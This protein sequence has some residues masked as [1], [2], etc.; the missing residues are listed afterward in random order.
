MTDEDPPSLE[1]SNVQGNVNDLADLFA[2]TSISETRPAPLKP[3]VPVPNKPV[4]LVS[5]EGSGLR[6]V[7]HGELVPQSSLVELATLASKYE[8]AWSDVYS[9]LFLSQTPILK[10]AKH[11]DGAVNTIQTY[12]KGSE[13]LRKAHSDLSQDLRGLVTLLVEMRAVVL[14][15]KNLNKP[16]S[17]YWSGTGDLKVRTVERRGNL[18]SAGELAMF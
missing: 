17:F 9:Q 12:T 6:H 4:Q 3:V 11:V 14:K 15:H 1:T 10:V 2:S 7:L 16:I 8:V 18:L 5:P 13:A